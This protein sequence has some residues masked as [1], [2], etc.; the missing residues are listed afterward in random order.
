[1]GVASSPAKT[2]ESLSLLLVPI[3]SAPVVSFYSALDTCFRPFQ[4]IGL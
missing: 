2:T 1:M 4:Y 3:Y